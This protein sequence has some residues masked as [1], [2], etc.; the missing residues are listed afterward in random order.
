[1]DL[2]EEYLKTADEYLTWEKFQINKL[3]K[4][5]KEKMTEISIKIKENSAKLKQIKNKKKEIEKETE[6]LIKKYDKK[7]YPS[8]R[9]CGGPSYSLYCGN[10]DCD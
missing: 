2:I 7:I 3:N 8:C 10:E 9:E 1:M 5:E 6:E 4:Q